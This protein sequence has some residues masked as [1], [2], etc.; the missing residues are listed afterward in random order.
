MLLLRLL[1]R[2]LLLR[3]CCG[4]LLSWRALWLRQGLRGHVHWLLLLARL[5]VR[6]ALPLLL[7][8]RR[9]AGAAGS[10]AQP[11]CG[12]VPSAGAAAVGATQ[13]A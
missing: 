12:R 5:L 13:T 6:L 9:G 8:R 1:L 2:R 4:L 7:W 10:A 11:Y 3:V